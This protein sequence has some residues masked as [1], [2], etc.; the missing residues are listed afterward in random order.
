[1]QIHTFI[2]K[3]GKSFMKVSFT[4]GNTYFGFGLN[5]IQLQQCKHKPVH[6]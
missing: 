3:Y 6:S 5:A 4:Y 2:P 1:M